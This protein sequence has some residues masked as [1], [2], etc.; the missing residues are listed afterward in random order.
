MAEK[1]F[2]DGI[3]AQW[4]EERPDL[5]ASPMAVIGRITRLQVHFDRLLTHD[6]LNGGEFDVLAALRRS[7]TPLNPK[8]LT[9]RLMLSAPA[10]TNRLDQLEQ[11]GLIRRMPDPTDRRALLIELTR[12]GR[13]LIDQAMTTHVE[14]EERILASLTKQ[15]RREIA[16]LLRKLLLSVEA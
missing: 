9:E 7:G 6:G 5:D 15:E 16:A 8:V 14:N 3:L 2:I 1:D 4:K 12:E 10:M 11:R 13:R